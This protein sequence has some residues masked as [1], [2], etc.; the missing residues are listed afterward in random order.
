VF[1]AFGDAFVIVAALMSLVK[2][3]G[4]P[5]SDWARLCLGVGCLILCM[6]MTK[7]IDLYITKKSFAFFNNSSNFEP[8]KSSSS[9]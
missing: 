4:S 2:E 8:P 6:N 5:M 3:L 7:Y 9:Y 1:S